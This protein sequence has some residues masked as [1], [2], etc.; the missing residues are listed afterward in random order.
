MAPVPMELLCTKPN[1]NADFGAMPKR[2]PAPHVQ[3]YFPTEKMHMNSIRKALII[4]VH[5]VLVTRV[6]A[7]PYPW[8]ID[9]EFAASVTGS[10]GFCARVPSSVQYELKTHHPPVS[11]T[12]L[13]PSARLKC[14]S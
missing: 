8:S 12:R 9:Q 2:S 10:V 3:N 13:E 1:K 7:Y 14:N 11:Q 6:C 4:Q 5:Q